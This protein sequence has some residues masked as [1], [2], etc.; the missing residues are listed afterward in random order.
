MNRYVETDDQWYTIGDRYSNRHE[1]ISTLQKESPN[2]EARIAVSLVER[3]GLVAGE[4]GGEDSSGR[5]KL[6]IQSPE[7][8]VNR[9]V[10]T[11][12]LLVS[13]IRDKNWLVQS[14]HPS[15]LYDS[16]EDSQ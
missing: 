8:V 11:A 10:T 12:E 6:R 4:E 5:A 14:P 2:L 9:A 1:L 3:W 7:E 16:L 15:E 13:A